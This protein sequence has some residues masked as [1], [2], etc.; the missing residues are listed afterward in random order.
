MEIRSACC[1]F[2]LRHSIYCRLKVAPTASLVVR[3]P[4]ERPEGVERAHGL[5]LAGSRS[6]DDVAPAIPDQSLGY[7][8]SFRGSGRDVPGERGGF[9]AQ[10]RRWIAA[11][12]QADPHRFGPVHPP[13]RVEQVCGVLR[14]DLQR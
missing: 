9:V 11:G 2:I 7:I 14:T 3:L 1:L 4:A 13:G 6:A 5:P 12:R 10:P 8:D